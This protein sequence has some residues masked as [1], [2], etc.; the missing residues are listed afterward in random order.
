MD[1]KPDLTIFTDGG[2]RGNPGPAAYAYVLQRPGRPDIE[3][4]CFLG[5]TT[6]NVAEYTGLVKALEH[7]AHLG[8]RRLAVFSDSELMVRQMNGEYRVK[9]EGLLPLYEQ[10]A[11]LR[12]EFDSVTIRHVRREHNKQADRLCNEAM[13]EPEDARPLPLAVYDD[14]TPPAPP[15]PPAPAKP[16]D[17]QGQ[18]VECLTEHA[19][20]W[21]AGDPTALTPAEA[22]GELWQML[23][24][25]KV[26]RPSR[27]TK[28]P[29]R[30]D[31]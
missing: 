16:D 21:A 27:K 10:A 17:V 28:R 2:S 30:G 4:K 8:A 3:V 15:A 22:W 14:D 12:D 9:N 5:R 31:T 24:D 18:V 25:A 29:P 20:K 23:L 13:D 7:A 26:V 6:N 19:R 11:A 1:V